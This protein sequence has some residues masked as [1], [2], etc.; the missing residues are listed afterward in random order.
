MEVALGAEDRPPLPAETRSSTGASTFMT[1]QRH[2][3]EAH[4]PPAT[5]VSTAA[6]HT[7]LLAKFE[8][9]DASF[10]D[11]AHTR[12]FSGRHL[13]PGNVDDHKDD[14]AAAA[15]EHTGGLLH[16]NLELSS[17]LEE[18]NSQHSVTYPYSAPLSP[19]ITPIKHRDVSDIRCSPPAAA[20]GMAY[21]PTPRAVGAGSDQQLATPP[22]DVG[23]SRSGGAAAVP[24][25]PQCASPTTAKAIPPI[26]AFQEDMFEWVTPAVGPS[27][28][29]PPVKLIVC[30]EPGCGRG[31]KTK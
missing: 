25:T 10:G 13:W 21:T 30:P 1:P 16:T 31:F 14:A 27:T 29:K 5:S 22:T 15:A 6:H 3:H 9:D 24:H 18:Y 8:A 7:S 19:I 23:D 11:A 2:L 28:T 17:L 4:R 12:M 20:A 26:T